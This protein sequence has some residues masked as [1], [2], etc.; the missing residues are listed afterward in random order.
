MDP[1]LRLYA[2]RIGENT[3]VVTGGAIK[4]THRME[5]RPH[6]QRQLIRLTSVKDWLRNEGILFPEDLTNLS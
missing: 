5:E 4:L 1:K 2:V 6:T 3:F